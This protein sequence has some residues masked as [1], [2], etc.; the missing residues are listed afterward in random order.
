MNAGFCQSIQPSNTDQ[1]GFTLIE[2]LVAMAFFIVAVA[3]MSHMLLRSVKN[4]ERSYISTQMNAAIYEQMDVLS[5]LRYTDT[6]LQEGDH[7]GVD[8]QFRVP[9]GIRR[10]QP[11]V[12]WVVTPTDGIVRGSKMITA[13][14][15][16]NEG[17][18]IRRSDLNLLRVRNN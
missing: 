16:W 2:V 15:T 7:A 4:N 11:A 12:S 14:V 17:N 6:N 10:H 13:T 3:G 18:R 1:R 9:D 8:F 5:L